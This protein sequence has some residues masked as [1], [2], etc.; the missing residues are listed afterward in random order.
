MLGWN[1]RP[2]RRKRARPALDLNKPYFSVS[3]IAA[4]LGW[5]DDK[6]RKYFERDPA[7]LK[8]RF[9]ATREKRR[10]TVLTIPSASLKR[11][12]ASLKK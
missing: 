7:T 4:Y 2:K 9:P 5:S 6:V 10:Y 8:E 3:D 12:V 11:L 1:K